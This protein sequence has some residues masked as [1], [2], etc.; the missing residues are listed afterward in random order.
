MRNMFSIFKRDFGAYFRSPIAYI[1]M[2][3]FLLVSGLIFYLLLAGFLQ[4]SY[5]ATMQAQGLPVHVN[6]MLIR[7]FFM[8]LTIIILFI[9]P[10]ITMRTFSEDKKS[11][12]IELLL[13]APLTAGQIVLGKFLAA[14]LFYLIM[15]AVTLLFMI[16]LFLWGEPE[17]MP[18]C[19]GYLGLWLLG[20]ALI[21]A[22]NFI[23]SLTENQIV[24]AAG[25]FT[26]TMLLW[27][28]G[29]GADVTGKIF[30]NILGYFAI[31]DRFE[32][33]AKGVLD[34]GHCV[35]YISLSILM[36]FLTYKSLAS[37]KWRA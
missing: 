4:Y 15:T 30:G 17:L 7:P 25:T 6:L 11:G 24:A 28:V 36:L 12:T 26:L 3:L 35:F 5:S 21:A 31:I 14:Y 1:V 29:F 22:G 10:I 34:S 9:V 23:S 18:I 33:F 8:N 37:S 2:A 20:A 19:V 32:D 27:I 16:F 13:T